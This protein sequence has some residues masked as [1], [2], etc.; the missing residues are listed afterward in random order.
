MR[1]LVTGSNGTVGTALTSRLREDGHTVI[2]WDR[3]QCSALAPE[4][5]IKRYVEQ[6]DPRLVFH[7]AVA[8][9]GTGADNEG[10]RVAVDWS[11]RIARAAASID[12]RT[13]LTSTVMVWT[14][15]NDGPYGVGTTPDATEGY[16]AEKIEAER[17]VLDAAPGNVV[18]RL[19]W[20]IGSGP[21]ANQM[22][23]TLHAWAKRDDGVIKASRKWKPA[24]SLLEDTAEA[25][26]S[27]VESAEGGIF[28]ID[29]NAAGHSFFDIAHA[30]KRRENAQW[31]IEADD[32]FVYDQRMLDGRIVVPDVGARLG[33]APNPR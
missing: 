14:Q 10:Y 25:L 1:V 18:A 12:A 16:G 27:L 20:Q 15:S 33:I 24:C 23:A 30:V 5:E 4:D 22:A 21:H 6:A 11:D 9:K 29:A 32:A 3:N 8:S 17:R 13:I 19:G 28:L 2:A 31:R 7:L 26:V